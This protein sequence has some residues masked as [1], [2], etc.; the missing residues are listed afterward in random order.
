MAADDAFLA[1]D[2][3]G[4]G[5][6]W[7]LVAPGEVGP[8]RREPT[9]RSSA[10]ALLGQLG[11]IRR[12]AAADGVSRWGVCLPGV[13]DTRTSVV[14]VAVNLGLRDF[15][16]L[17][18][19][20]ARGD[21]PEVFANDLVAAA[22]GEA[23]GGTLALLQIGTGVGAR[24]VVRGRVVEGRHGYA[25]EVGHL[26]FRQNGLRCTCGARGC[27]E[28]Y[29]GWGAIQRRLRRRRCAVGDPAGVLAAASG[30]A[31]ARVVLE[32]AVAG[33]GFAAAALVAAYD[34]GVI[35]LGGGLAAAWERMLPEAVERAFRGR[36]L[37]EVGAATRIE[38][39]RLGEAAPL[40]G[41]A[42]LAGAVSP[43]AAEIRS[44]S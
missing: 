27:V 10:D 39:S 33:L 5:V 19:L 32:D 3:G 9:D 4:T 34:P 44:E 7:A 29:A 38:T 17:E 35:R 24:A 15:P 13:I 12:R 21:R 1:V 23:G 40:L 36:V 11:R 2:V 14:R 28:A 37:A 16:F 30:D 22:A 6:K 25:G 41:L 43:S 20:T 42:L 26:V 18:A 31:G 8:I